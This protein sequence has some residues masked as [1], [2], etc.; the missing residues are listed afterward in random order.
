MGKFVAK[1]SNQ[2]LLTSVVSV[3]SVVVDTQVPSGSVPTVVIAVSEVL[4]DGCST[5]ES[6]TAHILD[7]TRL[8]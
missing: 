5:D 7:V 6:L 4:E 2:C 3:M 8:A 1:K